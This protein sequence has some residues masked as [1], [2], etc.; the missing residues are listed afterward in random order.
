MQTEKYLSRMVNYRKYCM[1]E[2][3]KGNKKL[4]KFVSKLEL[5]VKTKTKHNYTQLDT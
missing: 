1:R 3:K 5:K 2:K 4:N